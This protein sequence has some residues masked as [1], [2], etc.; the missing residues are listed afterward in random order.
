MEPGSWQVVCG[1]CDVVVRPG[2]AGSDTTHTICPSCF[3]V[4]NDQIA[5]VERLKMEGATLSG[6][7]APSR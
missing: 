7:H 3:T 1:W 4:L 6:R 2:S 5:A